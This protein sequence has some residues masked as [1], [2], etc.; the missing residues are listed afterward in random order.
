MNVDLSLDGGVNT[1]AQLINNADLRFGRFNLENAF[2]PQTLALAMTA[3]AQYYD[4]TNFVINTND[5]CTTMN[6]A[7]ISFDQWT[8]NLNPG[9]TTASTNDPVVISGDKSR[10]WQCR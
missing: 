7:K 6:A 5:N 10:R 3:Q 4:G 9:D 1:H 8:D 2:G